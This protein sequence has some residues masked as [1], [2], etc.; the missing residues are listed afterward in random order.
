MLLR[1]VG[2]P[3]RL[4]GGYL[5]GDYNELGGY[6]LVSEN[7]AHVWVEAFIE[8]RGWLR[9]DPSTFA[10]NAGNIFGENNSRNLMLRLRLVFDSINHAWNRAVITYDFEQQMNFV[11]YAGKR[12]QGID[13]PEAIRGIATY[14]AVI[15]LFLGVVFVGKRKLLFRSREERILRRFLLQAER[16]FGPCEGQGRRGLFEIAK[17]SGSKK[18]LEFVDIYAGAVYRDRVLTDEE[19]RQLRQILQGGFAEISK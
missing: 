15:I 8:G 6:Y 9:I 16:D 14:T 1:S 19:Y 11:R 2:V 13:L 7:M 17:E 12:L 10:E 3:S 18:M 5:G 4:V